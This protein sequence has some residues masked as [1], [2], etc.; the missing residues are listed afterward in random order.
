VRESNM[1]CNVLTDNDYGYWEPRLAACSILT[2]SDESTLILQKV[3]RKGSKPS[4]TES[5]L[6]PVF[7]ILPVHSQPGRAE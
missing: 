6:I 7:I 1:G 5:T 3:S 4:R 2:T